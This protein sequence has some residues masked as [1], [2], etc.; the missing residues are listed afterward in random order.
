MLHTLLKTMLLISDVNL[1][2]TE[3]GEDE[4]FY[5]NA[6]LNIYEWK[7]ILEYFISLSGWSL[8]NFK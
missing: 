6:L 8:G 4:E 1:V 2:S 5:S 7:S 3:F